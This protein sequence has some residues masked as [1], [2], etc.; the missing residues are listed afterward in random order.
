MIIA[1]KKYT[2]TFCLLFVFF[3]IDTMQSQDSKSRLKAQFAL[4]VNSPSSDG[5]VTGFEGQTYNFP[6][7]NLGLQYMFTPKL[8]AKL[9]YGFN[10]VKNQ[11]N[12][13]EFKLNYTRVNAQAVLDVNETLNF[14]PPRLGVFLHAGPGYSIVKPLGNYTENNISFLNIM[15]G[16]EVHY[17]ISD[18]LSVFTDVSYIQGFAKNFNPIQDGFGAF[19]GNMLTLNFGASISLSGC[20]FCNQ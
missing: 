16:V 14:L 9:D 15:A 7:V 11:D 2:L 18:K 10:R 12:A 4:G 19:N 17:G 1:F 20:Y 3:G 13:Q 5:F 6:S 8:G